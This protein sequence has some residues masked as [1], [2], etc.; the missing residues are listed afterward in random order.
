MTL[1]TL[2]LQ[3][4]EK[5]K[6]LNTYEICPVTGEKCLEHKC[7]Y[8]S[9]EWSGDDNYECSLVLGIAGKTPIVSNSAFMNLVNAVESWRATDK[10][11]SHIIKALEL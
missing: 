11:Y 5:M 10:K 1:M 8:F 2:V 4:G 6:K 9:N 7:G 3:K